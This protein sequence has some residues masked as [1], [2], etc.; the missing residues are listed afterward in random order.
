MA[1]QTTQER[2]IPE[3]VGHLVGQLTTLARNES[4]LARAEVSEKIDKL[5][6]AVILAGLGAILLLPA[7]IILLEAAAAAF[8]QDGMRPALAALIVGGVTL[9]IGI[10]LFMLGLGRFKAV[11]L[12]PDKTLRQLQRDVAIAK[13]VRHEHDVQ[14]AA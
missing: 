6:G 7:V 9:I 11:N 4:Q 2:S 1:A 10:L 12:V 14:R 3:I 13:E 5:I 8:V